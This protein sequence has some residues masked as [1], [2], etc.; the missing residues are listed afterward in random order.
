VFAQVISFEESAD[1]V[2]AGIKHVEEEVLPALKDADGL[3]GFWLVDRESGKRLSVMVWDSE[4]A[5]AAG[6]LRS[7]PGVRSSA[8]LML[9]GRHRRP[10]TAWRSTARSEVRGATTPVLMPQCETPGERGRFGRARHDRGRLPAGGAYSHSIVPGGFEVRSSVTRL[11]PRTSLMIRLET[12]SSRSY[13]RRA[14]SAV[15][16]SSDVTARITIGWA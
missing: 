7:R 14:Q 16:A 11:T 1:E 12:R 5:A 15:I 3:T 2:E 13:G 9:L 6:R 10:W 8:T 4:E